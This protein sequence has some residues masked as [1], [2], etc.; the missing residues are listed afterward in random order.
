MTIT[1]KLL[2][3]NKFSR[4]GTKR[5]STTKIA[6]HYV[7]NPGTTAINNRNYFE[8]CKTTG[9]YVSSNYIVGLDGEVIRC[10]PDDE[11]AYC[12]N[13]ANAYSISVET[14]HPDA[15]GKFNTATYNSLVELCAQ[16]LTK[17]NLTSEDLIRHFDVTG[18]VCPKCFVA[19]SKG[20]SDDDNLTSWKKFKADVG[21]KMSGS[22]ASETSTSTTA[23][24][25]RIRKTWWDISSQ[26]GA[27]SSLDNAKKAC[28]VGYTV[29]DKDGNAVYTNSAG[30][31]KGQA[32]TIK[33]NAPL[34][35]N[36]TTATASSRLS[37]GT[38]YLYDGIL[39]KNHRYRIT[40]KADSCGKTPVGK[41]VTGYVSL[42][43]FI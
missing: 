5:A 15:T 14:C 43:N 23:Q 8:N 9:T 26:I 16:L 22:K 4:P 28:T 40:T 36:E 31:T 39:C 38:F 37:G 1:E 6:L 32:V 25:Y 7:G 10:I 3:V 11:I 12:T 41:Y 21:A 42:D 20:G 33:A 30:Y 13:Q 24:L 35:A 34:F 27:Y 17:Y 19:V 18:K 29:F 2:T